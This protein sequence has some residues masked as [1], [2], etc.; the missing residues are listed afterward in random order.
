VSAGPALLELHDALLLDLD[1]VV[2]VGAL[3]VRH[4]V[5]SL[6]GASARGVATAYVTNNA[7]RPPA[8]VAE[9]LRSLGLD[10]ADHDV[11]TSAQAGAREAAAMLPPGSAVLAVGGPGVALALEA[12]G[13]R[14]VLSADESP[15]A[16]VMGY[17]PDVSWREL[18]EASYAVGRGAVLIATNLDLSIPTDRGIAPGNGTLVGAVTTATGVEPAVVAGKPFEPLVRESVERVAARR[19]LMVGD[20]LDTDIEAGHRSGIPTLM[21]LTGVHGVRDLL[22]APPHRRPTYVAADLRGLAEPAAS[23]ALAAPEGGR[24]PDDGLEALR[25]AA[26][27]AWAAADAGRPAPEADVEALAASVADALARP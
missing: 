13:L 25:D 7:A 14:P 2:Y 11:V 24:G 20:R 5:E 10:V 23:T 18:A 16:V 15:A 22:A 8:V 3:P 21:V 19:P 26:S 6:R 12:R 17:G 9:H 27:A 4:A 1:G